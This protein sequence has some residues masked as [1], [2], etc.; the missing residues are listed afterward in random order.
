[1]SRGLR[2]IAVLTGGGDAPGLNAVVRAVAKSAIHR[3][4]EV[5]G[6]ED[7]FEGFYREGG[8]RPLS[9]GHVRGI[10]QMGGSILRCS[11]RGDPFRFPAEDGS[12][13]ADRSEEV[14]RA[15][16]RLA[17]DALVVIGGDG[18]LQV[19]G[20]LQEKGVPVVGIPKTIDN[21]VW[22]TDVTFGFDTASQTVTNAVDRLHS[23]AASHQRVMVVEVMGRDAGW[24]AVQGGGS[25]G[26]DVLLIPEIPFDPDAI[27]RK[28][29]ERNEGGIGFSIVV[30][31][32]GAHARDGEKTVV[33]TA[34]ESAT[35]YE[36]LGGVGERVARF[37]EQREKVECRA[38][39]L[40]HVQRGGSPTSRDRFLGTLFG[41]GAVELVARGATGRMVAVHGEGLTDVPLDEVAG[42]SRRVDPEGL[43]VRSLEAIGVN[44]GR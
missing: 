16:D 20:R 21:D 36:R 29:R 18:S 14:V 3:G 30:V 10:L 33:V 37:I 44:F 25:G 22:G 31:A 41:V 39:V 11:N 42:K 38:T 43:E 19:G 6:V 7:G 40:G 12:G 13:P 35:G 4:W 1:L 17:L 2:R 26:G 27:C 34:E 5:L 28:V 8:I 15:V 24:I 32:E 9:S 23:T